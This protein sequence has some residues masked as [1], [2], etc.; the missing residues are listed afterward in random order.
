MLHINAQSTCR[1]L[2]AVREEI[3]RQ[4]L[5]MQEQGVIRPSSSP[6]ASPVVLVG[7]KDGT[8]RFCVDYKVINTVTKPDQFMLPQIDNL[9]DQ[10]GHSKYFSTLDLAAGYWQVQLSPQSREKTTF[11]TH[12]GL[13]ELNVMPF[14]LCNEPAVFQQL[15]QQ[16]LMSIHPQTGPS[17][18]SACLSSWRFSCSHIS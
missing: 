13:Y 1:T 14:G 15:K 9:L 12:R 11:T 2:F 18:A 10:L 4:L 17:F 7:K 6:W 8:L 3:S 5:Q 16:I